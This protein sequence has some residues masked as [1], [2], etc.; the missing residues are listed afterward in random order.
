MKLTKD[1]YKVSKATLKQVLE[2]LSSNLSYP[3]DAGD[4]YI[5][6]YSNSEV[7]IA[8]D[9]LKD[10][11]SKQACDTDKAEFIERVL[12]VTAEDY[13]GYIDWM[14]G[15]ES[16]EIEFF[17]MCNDLFCWGLGDAVDIT[18]ENI[19]ILEQ[20]FKDAG[21][22]G[23]DLFCCRVEKMRPQGAVYSSYPKEIWH[24]FD[25][26]G[27]E[28]EIGF[29]NPYKPGDY[30]RDLQTTNSPNQRPEKES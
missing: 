30:K 6:E 11:L 20:A 3:Y 4:G 21:N 26:C 9:D 14:I 28:R 17:A 29:G 22:Y 15:E 1:H 16:E 19:D 24:L 12:R 23:K 25:A 10:E 18:E 8:Y 5:E 7:E 13:C 2:A 27:P